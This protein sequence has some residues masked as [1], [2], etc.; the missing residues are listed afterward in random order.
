M[1][2]VVLIGRD[3]QVRALL[4]AQLLE[5]GV[6]VLACQTVAEA[7]E[8]LAAGTRLVVYD[9]SSDESPS[10]QRQAELEQLAEQS[11]WL[12]V[13]VLASRSVPAGIERYDFERVWFRPFQ[14][15]E[16]VRAIRQRLA[17]AESA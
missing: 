15:G 7:R 5:E 12:P 10:E 11:R 3:W 4:R 13:W 16:V 2:E 17:Q 9:A 1:A 8:Q 14:I 6:E